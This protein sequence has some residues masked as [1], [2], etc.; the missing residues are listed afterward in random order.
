[1]M[2]TW[3]NISAAA[4]ITGATA[5]W[6]LTDPSAPITHAQLA[7]LDGDVKNGETV[8]NIGGCLS[9]HASKPTKD[10]GETIR[11]AGGKG[12]PTEFGTFYAPNISPDKITG[13]G[14]WSTVEFANAMKHGVS[15]DN[16]HY[17]PAFPYTSYARMTLQDIVDL[18]A[19]LDTLPT[20]SQQSAEHKLSFPFNIR[21]GMGLWKQLYLN[22]D[23]IATIDQASDAVLRGQYLVEG[24][25]HCG[26]CHTPR[27]SIGGLQ[28][29]QWLMGAASPD[30][31]GRIPN[32]SPIDSGISDWSEA[33]IAEYLASGFTPEFDSAGGD[34]T[35]VIENTSKLP[36]SDR[37]AIAAYL[38]AL[39]NGNTP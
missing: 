21:R 35:E 26:E 22:D 38:K 39:P 18:K 13:I 8:F 34:M 1:M 5:F 11:L 14:A 23:S 12:F 25:G 16:Q 33:D 37:E 15:P 6:I 20:I 32:I 24:P 27:T 19:Y 9:C 31:K 29:D 36:A 4:V 10:G 7:N 17:Y 30:G 2:S 3:L 28:Y